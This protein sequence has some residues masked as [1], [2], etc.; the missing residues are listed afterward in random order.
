M[1]I[2]TWIR[3]EDGTVDEQVEISEP[4]AFS[5]LKSDHCFSSEEEKSVFDPLEAG[6]NAWLPF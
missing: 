6:E 3:Q 2:D 1:T 5:W 4:S